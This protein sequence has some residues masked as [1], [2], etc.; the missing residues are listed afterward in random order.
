V[1]RDLYEAVRAYATRF[2]VLPGHEAAAVER[3]VAAQPG[4]SVVEKH[5][6]SAETAKRLDPRRRWDEY[7]QVRATPGRY[8]IAPD[9]E[10]PAIETIIQEHERS[11]L[12]EAEP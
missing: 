2:L 11:T 9:H 12:V 5:G 6:A 3:V 1:R 4:Y 7:R 10:T 8:L